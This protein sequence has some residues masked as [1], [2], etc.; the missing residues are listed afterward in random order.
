MYCSKCGKEINGNSKY[1][2]DCEKTM[3]TESNKELQNMKQCPYC[4]EMIDK[5][6]STCPYCFEKLP[7]NKNLDNNSNN[8]AKPNKKS[9]PLFTIKST[10]ISIFVI[11]LLIV[12]CNTG[13][14]MYMNFMITSLY[15]TTKIGLE[16]IMI[17]QS[18]DNPAEKHKELL[19]AYAISSNGI[20][21]NSKNDMPYAIKGYTSWLLAS[22][23][24]K[25]I[26]YI[27]KDFYYKESTELIAK[28]LK[29]NPNNF[30]ALNTK[31]EYSLYLDKNYDKSLIYFNRA[32]DSNPKNSL[33]YYNK[34]KVFMYQKKNP[35]E[36]IE[37]LSKAIQYDSKTSIF[38]LIR[39]CVYMNQLND[40][41]SALDD[42]NNCI[43]LSSDT[44]L[45]E[46]FY[47]KALIEEKMKNYKIAKEDAL[48]ALSLYSKDNKY[49]SN[50]KEKDI[51]DI[52][53]RLD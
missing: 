37:L 28:S 23:K 2:E 41:T 13:K 24:G 29:I 17:S 19:H 9:N 27:K 4:K 11:L 49:Y 21:K 15:G 30:L 35:N 7:N 20:R 1:C 8:Q 25:D 14:N 3:A 47:I 50:I 43:K 40:L 33:A 39:A 18:I 44:P 12:I 31:G 42:I 10:A 46:S 51:K 36:I 6:L 34:A 48:K 5:Q 32:I 38:Y 22:T 53:K 52:M 45:A 16:H 26:K